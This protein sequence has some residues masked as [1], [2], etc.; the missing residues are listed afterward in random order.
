[1]EPRK[2]KIDIQKIVNHTHFVKVRMENTISLA[3][4]F[5]NDPDKKERHKKQECPVCFYIDSRIGG[6]MMTTVQCATCD[7]AMQYGSTCTD[8]LC[9]KCAKKMGLCRH[10]GSDID[11]K[12]R[13]KFNL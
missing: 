1:M 3:D 11:V 9:L 5:K 10:C 7:E 12:K 6:A 13:R 8:L 4:K 2:Q